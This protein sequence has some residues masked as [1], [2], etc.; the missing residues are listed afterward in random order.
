M[1]AHAQSI[2]LSRQNRVFTLKAVC[3][4]SVEC[5]ENLV[6]FSFFHAR[7]LVYPQIGFGQS[8]IV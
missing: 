8:T 5:P 2:V 3:E 4:L 1:Q 6:L 7:P